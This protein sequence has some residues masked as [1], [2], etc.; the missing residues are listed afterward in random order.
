MNNL[1]KGDQFKKQIKTLKNN[2]EEATTMNDSLADDLSKVNID[3]LLEKKESRRLNEDIINLKRRIKIL[4]RDLIK[5]R[6]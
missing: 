1:R 3:I 2:L 6:L 4:R 5:R